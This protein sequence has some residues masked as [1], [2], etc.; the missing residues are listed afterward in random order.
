MSIKIKIYCT[1]NPTEDEEKVMK[2]LNNIA[3][4]EKAVIID[5]R[6]EDSFIKVSIEGKLDILTKFKR[7]ITHRRLADL[8]RVMLKKNRVGR[9]TYLLLNKQVAFVGKISLCETR[10]ESPLGPIT[11][12]IIGD[13]E[14]EIDSA[15]AWLIYEAEEYTEIL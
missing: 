10:S 5:K 15:I 7:K 4:L 6:Q 14:D 13:K 9:R 2:A 8:I 3:N 12:E 1:I 11:I